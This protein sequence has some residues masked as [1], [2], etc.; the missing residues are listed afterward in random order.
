MSWAPG[1][2]CW[3]LLLLNGHVDVVSEALA[4]GWARPPFG[5]VDG[6]RLHGRG[7]ATW[8]C[9]PRCCSRSRLAC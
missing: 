9:M 6:G 4:D 8:A 1:G 5:E 3:R 7:A 2:I